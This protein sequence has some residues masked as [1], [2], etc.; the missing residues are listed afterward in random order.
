MLIAANWK[1]NLDKKSI[2]SFVEHLKIYNA[3]F[4]SNLSY[5][6]SCWGGISKY[7][8]QSIFSLQKRCVRLLFGK[9]INYD[10]P[11]F[12]ENC[13]RVRTYKQHMAV[14]NFQLEHTKTIFNE[15]NLLV[16]HHLYIYHTFCETFKIIK[17]RTPISLFTL[18][19]SSPS[20]TNMMLM[21][22]KVNLDLQKN[23][24]MS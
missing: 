11:E 17:Y 2:K 19:D 23:N 6:I 18:L 21:I 9:E 16:L 10:H 8:L 5:C 20:E 4:K 14:K 22:P 3:L 1:M 15:Q 7:K 12:Y 13:A 24:F